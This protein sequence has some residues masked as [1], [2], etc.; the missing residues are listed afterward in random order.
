MDIKV[1]DMEGRGHPK[2]CPC[3]SL[4]DIGPG[5]LWAVFLES[6]RRAV[7]VSDVTLYHKIPSNISIYLHRS[8][9]KL[10]VLVKFTFATWRHKS[11]YK[12]RIN[13]TTI[14]IVFQWK[15]NLWTPHYLQ[16][17]QKMWFRS[18]LGSHF[19]VRL[20]V[21]DNNNSNDNEKKHW[22]L[23]ISRILTRS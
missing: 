7:T 9:Q 16:F 1:M 12:F 22:N 6:I 19:S 18:H 3:T 14:S 5:S 20:H 21:N 11:N 4:M 2:R 23:S 8:H 10:C 17:S 15:R 13:D